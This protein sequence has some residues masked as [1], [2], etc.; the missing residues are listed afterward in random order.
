MT[1]GRIAAFAARCHRLRA[2]AI[3]ELHDGDEAVAGIAIHFLRA[4]VGTR[5]ERSQRSPARRSKAHW[6][7]RC[8]IAERLDDMATDAFK[9]VDL[10]PRRLATAEISRQ[11]VD[12]NR[13]R[14]QQPVVRWMVAVP[15]NL[16]APIHRERRGHRIS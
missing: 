13:Q 9:A 2:H 3:A 11:L 6:N 14:L 10:T 1:R 8:A 12:G 7:T 4:F 5:T 15:A 16:F